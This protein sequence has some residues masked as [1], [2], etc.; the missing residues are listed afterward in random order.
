MS[1]EIERALA[2]LAKECEAGS[3]PDP[4]EFCSRFPQ[5]GSE[6]R[7]EVDD[8]LYMLGGVRPTPTNAPAPE[9]LGDFKIVREIGRGGMGVV[10]E[11]EQISLR[12]KVALKVL[13]AHLTLRA[14]SV[15][16]FRREASTAARLRHPGIVEVFTVGDD[17]G[18]HYFAMEL[19]EGTPLSD[20]IEALR[21][22]ALL[23]ADGAAL[24]PGAAGSFAA[25]AARVALQVAEALEYAHRA[26][27][28]HRDVKPS[29]ILLRPDGKVVLTDFGLARESS[30]ASLTQTGHFGGTPHYVSPEQATGERPVDGRSDLF[31]LGITL[32]ELLTLRRPFEAATPNEVFQRILRDEPVSPQE[33][34]PKIPR[35]LATIVGKALEKDPKDRY[36]SAAAMAADLRA[37]LELRPISATPVSATT[38]VVRWARREPAKAT[39]SA[40]GGLLVGV[41]LFAAG[42]VAPRFADAAGIARRDRAEIA[43][44]EGFLALAERNPNKAM[45]LFQETLDLAPDMPEGLLGL[46]MSLGLEGRGGE[47]VQA[48]DAAIARVGDRP[49]LAR[50]RADALRSA[51]RAAE[52]KDLESKLSAPRTDVESFVAAAT[53]VRQRGEGDVP[54][55]RKCV[56]L[57]ERAIHLSPRARAVHYFD[58]AFAAKNAND[59]AVAVRVADAIEHLWPASAAGWSRV[60]YAV[61]TIDPPRAKAAYKRSLELDPKKVFS[62]YGLAATYFENGEPDAAIEAARAALAIDPNYADAHTLLGAALAAKKKPEEAE[63]EYRASIALEPK[64]CF[65]HMNLGILLQSRGQ[66]DAALAELKTAV[67]LGPTEPKAIANYGWTMRLK[68]DKRGAIEQLARASEICPEDFELLQMRATCHRE[69]AENAEAL[70]L[71]ERAAKLAPDKPFVVRDIGS[72]LL[73]LGRAEE[74]L[75]QFRRYLVMHP[76][77]TDAH[78][79][80]SAALEKM[81]DFPGALEALRKAETLVP[82]ANKEEVRGWIRRLEEKTAGATSAPAK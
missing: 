5:L 70:E 48:V 6:L 66:L 58:L 78:L 42:W 16:R 25:A 8:F 9:A 53:L 12:R 81:G 64:R 11:A 33:L 24:V 76:K 46:E 3:P 4:A 71:L 67:D 79:K 1:S 29:N 44:A 30:L 55:H 39:A 49:E 22:R 54:T 37:F 38:R 68:G 57:L 32:Y 10:Y 74:A 21:G 14:E 40:L 45:P 77:S 62:A 23:P 35:D 60:G 69:L 13:P 36:P 73:G 27:V 41:A 19:V 52:A 34:N 59:R 7:A 56:E 72:A 51:G 26:G 20:V 2:E 17:G 28:V 61:R 80:I 63:R 43:A 75:A 18:T 82:P 31:S 50:I 15:E 47:A 65:V